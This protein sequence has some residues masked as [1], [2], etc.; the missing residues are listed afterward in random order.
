[1]LRL[2][3]NLVHDALNRNERLDPRLKYRVKS[4]LAGSRKG[5]YDAAYR[6]RISVAGYIGTVSADAR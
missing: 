5:R 4:M 2:A 6:R 1:M 3:G